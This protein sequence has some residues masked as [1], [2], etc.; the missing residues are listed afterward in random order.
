MYATSKTRPALR[1]Y[2]PESTLIKR[3]DAEA[4]FYKYESR[5]SNSKGEDSLRFLAM[6][7]PKD[8]F[9]G[10]SGP[11][12]HY[13]REKHIG[14]LLI[15]NGVESLVSA[16][17]PR[18][19]GA[20]VNIGKR[21]LNQLHIAKFTGRNALLEDCRTAAEYIKLHPQLYTADLIVGAT[22]PPI[23]KA[24]GVIAGFHPMITTSVDREYK[25]ALLDR[26]MAFNAV[27]NRSIEEHP[28]MV[29]SIYMET[30]EFIQRFEA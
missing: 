8:W 7:C 29:C 4:L 10:R 15:Q 18:H 23:A 24:A 20:W 9:G 11:L 16:Y 14:G 26:H 21:N 3:R 17:D 13:K 6:A 1:S 19:D 30:K 28:F 2:L 12:E 25:G 27:N 22:Y 5:T